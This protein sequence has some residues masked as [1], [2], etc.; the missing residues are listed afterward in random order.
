MDSCMQCDASVGQPHAKNCS[1]DYG[2]RVGDPIPRELWEASLEVVRSLE[3]LE[4]VAVKGRKCTCRIDLMK[5]GKKPDITR[6]L[7]KVE[8]ASIATQISWVCE[9]CTKEVVLISTWD[10]P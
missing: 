4:R 2:L 6:E 9:C 1:A 3:K 8:N 7:Y 10:N 5:A